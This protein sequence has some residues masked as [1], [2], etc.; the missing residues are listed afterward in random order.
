MTVDELRKY[1]EIDRHRLAPT[2]NDCADP[3]KYKKVR[4]AIT[5]ITETDKRA[6]RFSAEWAK[7]MF[8]YHEIS[9]VFYILACLPFLIFLLPIDGGERIIYQTPEYGIT[10]GRWGWLFYVFTCVLLGINAGW[11]SRT[12]RETTYIGI[13]LRYVVLIACG[14]FG[15][16]KCIT[17]FGSEYTWFFVALVGGFAV[18][19]AARLFESR[20][21]AAASKEYD[22][23]V[24][25]M[26]ATAQLIKKCSAAFEELGD[27]RGKELAE[28]FPDIAPAPRQ[29]WFD[30]KRWYNGKNILQYPVCRSVETNFTAPFTESSVTTNHTDSEQDIDRTTDVV[31]YAQEFGYKDITADEAKQLLSAGRI[32]PFFNLGVPEFVEGLEYKLFRHKWHYV[33]TMSSKGVLHKTREVESQEQKNFDVSKEG[34][35][36]ALYKKYGKSIEELR[37]E[38]PETVAVYEAEMAKHRDR[39]G[40]TTEHFDERVDKSYSQE[41]KGDEIGALEIRTSSGELLGLYCG[42]SLQSIRFAERIAAGETD[43]YY[44]PMMTCSGNAQRAFLYHKFVK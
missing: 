36:Y 30:F 19:F 13:A 37:K 31:I 3:K 29:P 18:T 39:I 41:S 23:T 26:N 5:T 7:N 28:Q 40:T 20:R 25:Q 42:P 17:L 14:Y 10:I 8:A 35:E 22:E 43:F 33:K 6:R 4:K 12:K 11:R 2:E 24:E 34:F 32:D 1:I 15:G 27:L 9:L 21:V 16:F 44:D 38:M